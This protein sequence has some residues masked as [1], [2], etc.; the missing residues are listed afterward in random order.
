[1]KYYTLESLLKYINDR[2]YDWHWEFADCIHHPATRMQFVDHIETKQTAIRH[3]SNLTEADLNAFFNQVPTEVRS[4]WEREVKALK[5]KNINRWK[6]G[7]INTGHQ[8]NL[9]ITFIYHEETHEFKIQKVEGYVDAADTW[10]ELYWFTLKDDLKKEIELD[11]KW[12]LLEHSKGKADSV[13][14]LFLK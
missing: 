6:N 3:A 12:T 7:L 9:R 2:K 13:L 8:G 4:G 14:S 10:A 5:H 11:I 1:M